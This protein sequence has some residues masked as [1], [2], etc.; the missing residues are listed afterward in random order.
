MRWI[1]S[2]DKGIPQKERVLFF[3]CLLIL[4]TLFPHI[5]FLENKFIDGED[6][7]NVVQ[8]PLIRNISFHGF[9]RDII[10]FFRYGYPPFPVIYLW[11]LIFSIWGLNHIG[12]HFV[13]IL[14]HILNVSLLF[15]LL[16]RKTRRIGMAFTGAL[17]YAWHPLHGEAVNWISRQDILLFLFMGLLYLHLSFRMPSW[18]YRFLKGLILLGAA[19]IF[20]LAPLFVA[21]AYL[22]NRRETKSSVRY[23]TE[24]SLILLATFVIWTGCLSHRVF[25]M[26]IDRA[27]ASIPGLATSLFMP[28]KIHFLLPVFPSHVFVETLWG[29]GLLAGCLILY[30]KRNAPFWG[31]VFLAL[32]SIWL[33]HSTSG[34]FNGG[35]AL[36]SLL[37]L[38]I[39]GVTELARFPAPRGKR[40]MAWALTGVACFALFARMDYKRSKIWGNTESLVT[41]S[42]KFS[43]TDSLLWAVKGHYLAAMGRRSDMEKAF[44]H[45]RKP[46]AVV[47]C[48]E[49]KA[50]HLVMKTDKSIHLFER[51]F[52]R[53]PWET[54]NK[55]CRFDFAVL[56]AQS[57]NFQKAEREFQDILALD[58]FFLFAWHNLGTLL[59]Q[60]KRGNEGVQALENGL[61]I[62]PGYRPSLENLALYYMRKGDWERTLHY[63][64][65]AI[66]TTSCHDT[67]MFYREWMKA[68]EAK[69]AFPY[70]SY[71]WARLTPPD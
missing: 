10:G 20:P 64:Q 13:S 71:Q 23:L 66:G 6:I 59:I 21:A 8:N 58:P 17:F 40:A 37:W 39:G 14:L 1:M 65:T 63:L 49:A 68:A 70:A 7:F 67:R 46:T 4:L 27:F 51:L 52:Q 30:L 24:G 33:F 62:A 12:F 50:D 19:F 69:K 25:H 28:W 36:P 61:S 29:I 38:I 55:F 53:Y 43:S 2:G 42:L 5:G 34:R 3:L 26:F 15:L 47:L 45:V 9:G 32:L 48:L 35:W 54:K 44:S 60:S 57:G 11:G 31:F 22:L 18:P 16:F 56:K 41:D